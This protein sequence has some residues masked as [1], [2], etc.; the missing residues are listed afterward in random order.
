MA[1][2]RKIVDISTALL[3]FVF[4]IWVWMEAR[5]YEAPLQVDPLGPGFWPQMLACGIMLFS[6]FLVLNALF[7]RSQPEQEA[8]PSPEDAATE[9]AFSPYR[10]GGVVLLL[11]FCVL[12]LQ[13]LGYFIT[14]PLFILGLL[15]LLGVRSRRAIL[16]CTIGLPLVWGAL[17]QMALG[18]HLPEGLL[19]QLFR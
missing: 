3:A 14:T 7:R 1:N 6:F 17:F 18:V 15:L 8:E 5:D 11:L 10:F 16:I 9:E 19:S 13:T 2:W 4:G 12:T